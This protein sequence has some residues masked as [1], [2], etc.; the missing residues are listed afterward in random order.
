MG[1][2]YP[3]LIRRFGC[4]R[5][6]ALCA[7]VGLIVTSGAYAAQAGPAKRVLLI[8]TGSRFSP[9]FALVD[10]ARSIG[11]SIDAGRM[12]A[13]NLDILRFPID[14]FSESLVST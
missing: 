12:Y 6:Y 14:R 3:R 5:I 1:R 13:E 2:S 7:I 8:S 10:H 11:K 9:G 4:W